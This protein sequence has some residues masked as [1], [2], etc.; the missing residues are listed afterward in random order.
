[1]ADSEL[2]L[3]DYQFY[4]PYQICAVT[5]MIQLSTWATNLLLASQGRAP[6]GVRAL[7]SNGAL[8][9]EHR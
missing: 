1:M 6:F 8:L 9:F 7:I 4:Y 2:T 3:C 5:V